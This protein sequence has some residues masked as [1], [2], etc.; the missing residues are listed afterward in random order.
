M[1]NGRRH[2]TGLR[3]FPHLLLFRWVW[4]GFAWLIVS[5]AMLI[6]VIYLRRMQCIACCL[7][8]VAAAVVVVIISGECR[9]NSSLPFHSMY[10]ALCIILLHPHVCYVCRCS[11]AV[12]AKR[13]SEDLQGVFERGTAVGK[14]RD[15]IVISPLFSLP[16]EELGIAGLCEDACFCS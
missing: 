13:G 4:K 6:F 16:K 12:V 5:N 10:C 2:Q 3:R 15:F 11:S 7:P 14:K 9:R 1:E 8:L